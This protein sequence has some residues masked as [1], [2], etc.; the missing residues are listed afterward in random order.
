MSYLQMYVQKSMV[1]FGIALHL[2]WYCY[3]CVC[4]WVQV[5]QEF[6]W[7]LSSVRL[8]VRCCLSPRR[9]SAS[10]S[11]AGETPHTPSMSNSPEKKSTEQVRLPGKFFTQ[12]HL[13]LSL[14]LLPIAGGSF[15]HFVWQAVREL[16]SSI[17]PILL[18]CPSGATGLNSVS[19]T[20]H[21]VLC[22]H[23]IYTYLM[24]C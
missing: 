8:Q 7:R 18:P 12:C 4:V 16:Q 1:S 2:L 17:L 15:R 6:H 14:S 13:S 19:T 5:W 22:L 23:S 9:S 21:M 20:H 11:P 3:C 10:L 24:L